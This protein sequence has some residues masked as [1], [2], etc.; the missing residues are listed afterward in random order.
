MAACR[1][2]ALASN[3]GF[4]MGFTR[5]RLSAASR[6]RHIFRSPP[7]RSFSEVRI[8]LVGAYLIHRWL[9]CTCKGTNNPEEKLKPR[10]NLPPTVI[11]VSITFYRY[12][13][14]TE[15]HLCL[16]DRCSFRNSRQT[17]EEEPSNCRCESVL[18]WNPIRG[19]LCARGRSAHSRWKNQHWRSNNFA[20]L[21]PPPEFESYTSLQNINAFI[22]T[23]IIVLLC[24]WQSLYVFIHSFIIIHVF[25]V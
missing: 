14:L 21:P 18:W 9:L 20:F 23:S 15:I 22:R 12:N 8:W 10:R 11:V 17:A 19:E 7:E 2:R 4:H 1:F 25:V 5:M 3:G 24:S 6:V 16:S 13:L